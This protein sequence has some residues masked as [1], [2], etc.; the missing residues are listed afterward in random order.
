MGLWGLLNRNNKGF[1]LTVFIGLNI[2]FAGL[3]LYCMSFL[4]YSKAILLDFRC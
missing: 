3:L 2:I 4:F 1:C